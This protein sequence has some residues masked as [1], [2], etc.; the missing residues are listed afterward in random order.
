MNAH[1]LLA[2]AVF[3]LVF[4][5]ACTAPEQAYDALR[6]GNVTIKWYGHATVEITGRTARIYTDP[7]ALPSA[8]NRTA[9]FVLLTH[10]HF[11]HCDVNKT[12]ALIKQNTNST[13]NEY[14]TKIFGPFGC[15]EKIRGYT[16][17][18]VAGDFF[19]Y[20]LYKVNITAVDAYN[21]GENYHPQGE[22]LG[23][24]VELEGKRI[25]IAGD[26]DLIPEMTSLKNI[27][28][29]VLPIGGTYTMNV[30][31][32]AEAARLI[33]PKAVI[34]IHYNSDDFGI[35]NIDADPR[36]LQALLDGTGIDV[37]VLERAR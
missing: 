28:V 18:M 2:F 35:G 27:D 5:S 8:F 7:F 13:F 12:E 37:V 14:D 32:A 1:Y 22:G 9:E 19:Y 23:Y 34:P 29:A 3:A 33:G 36:R 21:I 30:E 17:S 20:D 31:E 6:T 11:D 26:T 4:V 25:Y 16:N 10:D 24:V 15:V